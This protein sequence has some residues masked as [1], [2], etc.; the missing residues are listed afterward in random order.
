MLARD[1]H[2]NLVQSSEHLFSLD[3]GATVESGPGWVFAAGRSVHPAISNAAFRVD[4]GLDPDRFMSA[5]RAFFDGHGRGFAIWARAGVAEDSDLVDAAAEAGI[6][7]VIEMPEMVLHEPLAAGPALNGIELQRVVSH[8]DARDY[9]EVGKK[10]YASLGFPPEV[11]G[12]YE[13]HLPL[14]A[15][16]VAAFVAR[17]GDR[18]VGI[19]LTAVSEGVA[20]IYWVGST[21]D[22]R[23]RGVGRAVTAAAVDAGFEM[24]AEVASLQAS[25][26]GES[27]YRKMGFETIFSYRLLLSPPLPEA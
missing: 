4:D 15:E 9:W 25:P 3:P 11:F 17:L 8:A 10:A 27:L 18:P 23:H 7:P 21:E 2:L 6:R 14:V 16:N 22:V 5:A 24:G 12:Y 1:V 20:G 26:M 19:A 13:T